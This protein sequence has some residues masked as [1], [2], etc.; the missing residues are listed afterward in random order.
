[1]IVIDGPA[2]VIAVVDTTDRIRSLLEEGSAAPHLVDAEVGQGIRGLILRG[3]IEADA[4]ER[5]LR[6]AE[7]LVV[8]RYPHPPLQARAWQLRDGVSFYDGLYVALAEL[9]GLPLVTADIKLVSATGP[10]C[11]FQVV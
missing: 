6:A 7:H 10:R 3:M 8:D 4:A 5:S 11:P 2:L 1:V 9:L